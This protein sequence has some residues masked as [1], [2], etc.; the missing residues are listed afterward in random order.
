MDAAAAL[1]ATALTIASGCAGAACVAELEHERAW[2]LTQAVAHAGC[3]TLWAAPGDAD[4]PEWLMYLLAG[5]ADVVEDCAACLHQP[6][7]PYASIHAEHQGTDAER[8]EE[9]AGWLVVTCLQ[10]LVL[11]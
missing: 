2:R 3:E 5:A 10:T 7:A 11:F 1:A 8:L 4:W 6:A 9:T